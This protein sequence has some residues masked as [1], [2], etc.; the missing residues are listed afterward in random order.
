L[1]IA[2]G[3]V[4]CFV[5]KPPRYRPPDDRLERDS[6]CDPDLGAAVEQFLVPRV[7]ELQ[8][9]FGVKEGEAL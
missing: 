5:D 1:D 2:F 9:I 3:V 7:A 8:T 6:G 4:A